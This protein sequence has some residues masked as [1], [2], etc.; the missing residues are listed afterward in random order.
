MSYLKNTFREVS[1]PQDFK[2]EYLSSP[3]HS[4]CD[5]CSHTGGRQTSNFLEIATLEQLKQLHKQSS[6][7][8]TRR[9]FY[10]AVLL[11]AGSARETIGSHTYTFSAG[12]LYFIP[13]YQLHTIHH[14]SEDIRGYHCIFD[15][16]YFLLC[17]KN[18]VRLNEYP[19]FQHGHPP[20]IDLS[21]EEME[22][23]VGLFQKLQAEYCQR[24]HFN[25]DLLVRLYLNVLLIEAERAY[26]SHE[27]KVTTPLPRKE[28][29]VASFKNLVSRHYMEW[30][31]VTD[32][33][34]LLYVHPHY[35]N[36][37]IKEITGSPASSFIHHQLIT[38]AKAQLIQSNESIAGIAAHL[39]FADQSYFGRFFRKH[40]GITPAQ[41]RQQHRHHAS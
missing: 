5:S 36:D 14:W 7:S 21:Q 40:T 16:D 24:Q 30:K 33:A 28:Q 25:D 31:Q 37:T 29:L 18:Q 19:F 27:N 22:G 35:L 32:Y 17:L 15:A 34:R 13:E 26:R 23:M 39:N 9:K 20:F 8:S 1:N 12:M 6:F 11:T 2:E 10:T 3:D 4:F 41:Y 38:E